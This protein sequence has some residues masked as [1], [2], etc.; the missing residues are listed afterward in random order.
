MAYAAGFTALELIIDASKSPPAFSLQITGEDIDMEDLLAHAHTPAILSGSLNLTA[1]LH[2]TGR[3]TREIAS[4]LNGTFGAALENGRVRRIVDFLSSD[5]FDLVLT[6]FE[7]TQGKYTDMR[8]LVNQMK[9]E[10]GKGTI[11]VFF[12]DTPRTRV[13]AAGHIDLPTEHIDVVAIPEKKDRLLKKG[14]AL[15]IK[16][17]LTNPTVITLPAKEA[18]RIYGTILMP[19]AFLSG[20]ILGKLVALIRND[21]DASAC[22]LK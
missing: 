15:Q 20:R 10:K 7:R 4:N 2:S 5:A 3:S 9:F 17:V 19:Y 12:M 22:I 6:P 18:I 1:D 14:S 11:E 16:G 8:C 21:K 13:G